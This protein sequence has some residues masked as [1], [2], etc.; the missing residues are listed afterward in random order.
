MCVLGW[1]VGTGNIVRGPHT[2]SISRRKLPET[3]NQPMTH[4][5]VGASCALVVQNLFPLREPHSAP[6][7]CS[8]PKYLLGRHRGHPPK[9]QILRPPAFTTLSQI[10]ILTVPLLWLR[11]VTY[12]PW[13]YS[14]YL[15]GIC[16]H[17][18]GAGFEPARMNTRRM[19]ASGKAEHGHRS[20]SME[21]LAFRQGNIERAIVQ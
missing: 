11:I 5:F 1:V 6:G 8:S 9:F 7:T 4:A 21:L 16:A 10:S 20:A 3:T 18:G 13:P 2:I 14:T 19:L 17:S 12:L 15:Q